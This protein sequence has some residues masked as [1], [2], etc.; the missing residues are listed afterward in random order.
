MA[1]NCPE[2]MEAK[3]EKLHLEMLIHDKDQLQTQL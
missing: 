1:A 3:P 2:A